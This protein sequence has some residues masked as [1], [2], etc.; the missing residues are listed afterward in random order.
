MHSILQFVSFKGA[1]AT[2]NDK[3]KIVSKAFESVDIS[4]FYLTRF[5]GKKIQFIEDVKPLP[6]DHQVL[7]R[8]AHA[9]NESDWVQW[10]TTV[11]E[12]DNLKRGSST[13]L[14]ILFSYDIYF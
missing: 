11:M 12:I 7:F 3:K 8:S 10:F 14:D 5:V 6:P 2:L 13:Y 9:F 1:T 4:L